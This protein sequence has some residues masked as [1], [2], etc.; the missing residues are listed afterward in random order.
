ME[1]GPKGATI[2]FLS[3]FAPKAGAG[4][5][6]AKAFP[7]AY[8]KEGGATASSV[9]E[10]VVVYFNSII[11]RLANLSKKPSRI[12][13]NPLKMLPKSTPGHP[14]EPFRARNRLRGGACV[15]LTVS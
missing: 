15:I 14:R 7:E 12:I 2:A 13:P 6:P 3:G 9:I 4:T 8:R 5:L 10:G 11:Q 1:I